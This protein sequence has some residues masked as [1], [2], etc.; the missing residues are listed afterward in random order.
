MTDNSLSKIPYCYWDGNAESFGVYISK[1][2]AYAKFIVIGDALYPVLMV[3][4]P[5]RLEFAVIDVTIPTNLP[6][7]D[8]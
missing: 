2:K 5:T 7:V 4:C 3:N 6:L 8:L 1:I